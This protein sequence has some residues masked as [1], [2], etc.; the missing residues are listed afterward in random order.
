MRKFSIRLL[1]LLL[2]FMMF[3]SSAPY[4]MLVADAAE[5]VKLT[6]SSAERYENTDVVI[7]ISISADSGMAAAVFQLTYD[8]TKLAYKSYTLGSAAAGLSQV[9]PV[10]AVDGNN[11]TIIDNFFSIAAINNAGS[12]LDITFTIKAGWSG[13]TQLTLT[14]YEVFDEHNAPLAASKVDG[15]V[16][17]PTPIITPVE[18]SGCVIDRENGLI[19]IY[20]GHGEHDFEALDDFVNVVQGYYLVYSPGPGGSGTGTLVHV[21]ERVDN[22]LIGTYAIIIVGDVNGDGN[23]TGID[24]GIMVNVE[25][26]LIV[27]SPNDDFRKAGDVNGDGNITGVDAGIAVDFEN[28]ATAIDIS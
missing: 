3:I 15:Y 7:S 20:L 22:I 8:N 19:F 9:N 25:N 13:S 10:Y 27:W 11:T 18:G 16:E 5:P 24:A 14:K 2:A 6:V 4:A 12:L 17:V 1:G 21:M 23:I 26:Y 28:Y